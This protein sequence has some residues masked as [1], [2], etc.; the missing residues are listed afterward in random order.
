MIDS[1]VDIGGINEH[2]CLNILLM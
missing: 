1:F 2:H